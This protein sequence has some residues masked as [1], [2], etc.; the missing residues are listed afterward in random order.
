MDWWHEKS[1]GNHGFTPHFF[2]GGATYGLKNWAFKAI[3]G[4]RLRLYIGPPSCTVLNQFFVGWSFLVS[5]T[6]SCPIKLTLA[7]K[8]ATQ[9]LQDRVY[10]MWA[11]KNSSSKSKGLTWRCS[12]SFPD[13]FRGFPHFRIPIFASQITV[14]DH[15]WWLSLTYFKQNHIRIAPHFHGIPG[16]HQKDAFSP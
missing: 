10:W 6:W 7:A 5:V 1:A 16:K 2:W 14:S 9:W 13:N 15:I 11:K 3:L 12:P 8:A 4:N